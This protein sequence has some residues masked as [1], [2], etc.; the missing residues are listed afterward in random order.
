MATVYFPPKAMDIYRVF[1]QSAYDHSVK[2]ALKLEEKLDFYIENLAK[3]TQLCPT[4]EKYPSFRKCKLT[5]HISMVYRLVS[6]QRIEV[7]TS[8]DSR[9]N[10]GFI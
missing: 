10:H 6:E 4:L 3:H 1:L 5:K 2:S 7:V 9:M 8:I